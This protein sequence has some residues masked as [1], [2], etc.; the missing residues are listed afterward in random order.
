MDIPV[1]RRKTSYAKP[2]SFGAAG[3]LSLA[4]LYQLAFANFDTQ[5]IDRDK[6]RFATV[7]EGLFSVEVSG[8]GTLRAR[9]VEWV[10][11][12]VAGEVKHLAVQAG[13][14]V[15]KGQLILQL[16]NNEIQSGRVK[17]ESRLAQA[18]A[19]HAAKAFDLTSQK[20]RYKADLIKAQFEWEEAHALYTAHKQLM[21]TPN[22]PLS[23]LDFIASTIREKRM[24]AML[25]VADEILKNFDDLEK[26]QQAETR[27]Q[28]MEVSEE[29]AQLEQQ[30]SELDIRATRDGTIQDL[31]LKLGQQLQQG[32]SIAKIS[33]SNDLYVELKVP[34][35]QALKL[36]AGQKTTIEM[37][38][39]SY[40][41]QVE[42][43]DPNVKGTTVKVDVTLN[44]TPPG[45]RVDMF[46]S[47]LIHIQS[48]NNTLYVERPSNSIE[49]GRTR[50]Y[51]VNTSDDMAERKDVS[52]GMFSAS[53]VQIMSGLKAGDRI[54]LS[55]LKEYGGPA[56]LS[57]Y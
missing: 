34:A 21:A 56:K 20:K 35:Y 45:A 14:E 38:Q 5:Q 23:K 36:A 25:G 7:K 17:V 19:K 12:R 43:I 49:N 3:I 33:N 41:G 18:Q 15:K 28:I 30:I 9:N 37:N 53:H 27:A 10:V 8:N 2:L 6:L 4:L 32:A 39:T 29:R 1:A 48:V 42:R 22:P 31:D 16:H 51:K 11:P 50:L 57:L 46:V 13:D 52:M 24:K 26:S 44:E 47:A 54:I 55:D 40:S